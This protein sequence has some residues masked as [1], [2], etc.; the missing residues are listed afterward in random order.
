[1]AKTPTKTETPIPEPA[2]T[3]VTLSRMVD[4]QGHA[5]RPGVKHVVDAATLVALGD[6]VATKRPLNA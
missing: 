4:L 5:Y 6:A 2:Y 1:M 3:E